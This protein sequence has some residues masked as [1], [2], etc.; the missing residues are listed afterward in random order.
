M[1]ADLAITGGTIVNPVGEVEYATQAGTLVVEEGRIAAIL[2]PADQPKA[3]QVIDAT[4]MLVLPGAIDPHFHCRAPSF[5]QRGDFATESRAAAAGGV[6][7]IFEMPISNPGVATTEALV[8]RGALVE[9]DAYVN[10]GLYGAPGLLDAHEVKGMAQAGAIAFKLFMTEAPPGREDEFDG[11]IASDLATICA[12]LELTRGTGLRCAIHCED[13]SL[14]D[15]YSSKAQHSPVVDWKRHLMSRPAVVESTAIAGVLQLSQSLQAPIHIVHVSAEASVALVQAA[16]QEGVPVTAET[17]PHYLL[18][19]EE[20]LEQ[21][22]P[23]GK[24]N[25]P[26]RTKKDQEALWK[27]LHTGAFDFIATDHAPFTAEEKEATWGRILDSPPGHPGV[28]ALVPLLLTWGLEGTF[29]LERAVELASTNA[30]RS[31]GLYPRKGVLRPGSDADICVYD[32]RS[33]STLEGSSWL[34]KG[35]KASRLYQG[36]PVKGSVHGTVVAGQVVYLDGTVVGHP[37]IGAWL[38]SDSDTPPS[39]G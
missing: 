38:R 21:V 22:G 17:C 4:E 18:F 31:F 36:M 16:K 25:P 35:A 34:T 1:T 29:P 12:A 15:L 24:I 5:P 33:D 19:T 10:I 23:Y 2:N 30:A 37:G 20:I 28:E 39:R 3:G 32:P 9:R 14:I 8:A 26:M 11:L 13:Q 7:T 27:G 6:T